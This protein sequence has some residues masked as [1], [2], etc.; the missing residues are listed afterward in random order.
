MDE[1]IILLGKQVVY[2]LEAEE[3][4]I[5][6]SEDKKDPLGPFQELSVSTNLSL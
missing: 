2:K 3:P 5:I 6:E 1:L 4:D